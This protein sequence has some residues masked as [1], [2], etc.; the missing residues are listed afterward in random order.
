MTSKRIP[1]YEFADSLGVKRGTM[2]RWRHEGMPSVDENG[3]IFVAP[4]EARAWINQHARLSTFDKKCHVYFA[5]KDGLI[6]I[7]SSVDP[8][9]RLRELRVEILVTTPG[10]K[11]TEL[12]F[13][14]L[15]AD[16][17]VGN[18]WFRPVPELLEVIESLRAA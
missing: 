5:R 10:D 7:G 11:R 8:S 2:K 3:R 17:A 14:T 1:I 13:H 16:A 6:K 18:E 12:A 9:R 15:F 4:A